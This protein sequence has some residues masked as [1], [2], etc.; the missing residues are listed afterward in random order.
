[1]I[2]TGRQT[3]YTALEKA[4]ANRQLPDLNPTSPT[5]LLVLAHIIETINFVLFSLV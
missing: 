1:M 2:D 3:N 5:Q 4:C